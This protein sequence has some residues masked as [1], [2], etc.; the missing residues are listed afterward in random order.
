MYPLRPLASIPTWKEQGITAT[1]NTWR[2][3]WR[4]KGMGV[5][6]I[7]F[8]DD[9]LER[10][11]RDVQWKENLT[12]NLW[13]GDYRNSRDTLRYLDALHVEMRDVLKELGLARKLD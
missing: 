11:S 4:P 8:W 10:V 3:L 2:G 13:E 1:L 12:T 6:Q 5:D 7:A 9:A